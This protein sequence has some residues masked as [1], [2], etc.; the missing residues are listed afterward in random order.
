MNTPG[1]KKN[2]A[3]VQ[4]DRDGSELRRWNVHNAFPAEFEAASWDNS[5]DE[6]AIESLVL[7][8]DYFDQPQ[9]GT[10]GT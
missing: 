10:P 4:L 8:Y 9:D 2:L 5:A 6:V 7:A 1:Y 3:V